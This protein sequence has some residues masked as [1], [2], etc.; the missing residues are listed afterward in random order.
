MMQGKWG[1]VIYPGYMAIESPVSVLHPPILQMG[2]LWRFYKI[3]LFEELYEAIWVGL[4]SFLFHFT[5]APF[6]SLSIWSHT[7][8]CLHKPTST[9]FESKSYFMSCPAFA[10]TFIRGS[11]SLIFT[12]RVKIS[13]HFLWSILTAV[14]LSSGSVDILDDIDLLTNHLRK[15]SNHDSFKI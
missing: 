3:V 13:Q 6:T 12:S 10:Y 14:A 4:G 11:V 2:K 9:S 15:S 5:S 7:N 1:W 8:S